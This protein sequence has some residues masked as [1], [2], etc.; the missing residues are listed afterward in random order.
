M[1][2]VMTDCFEDFATG[3]FEYLWFLNLTFHISSSIRRKEALETGKC[4]V[5]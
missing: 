3:N 1:R 2:R 4:S 5:V